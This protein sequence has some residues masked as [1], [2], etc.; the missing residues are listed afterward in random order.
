MALQSSKDAVQAPRRHSPV[1]QLALA[2]GKEHALPQ[3]PQFDESVCVL[4]SQPSAA[5]ALQSSKPTSHA[6]PQAPAAHSGV[7]AVRVGHG[8]SQ[9]PQ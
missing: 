8:A 2:R 1:T 7:L 3:V 9:A 5:R 6:K 4:T